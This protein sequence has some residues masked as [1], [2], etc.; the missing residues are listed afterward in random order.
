[1]GRW[2]GYKK[3]TEWST[4]LKEGSRLVSRGTSTHRFIDHDF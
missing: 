1:M 3:R 4:G 2:M